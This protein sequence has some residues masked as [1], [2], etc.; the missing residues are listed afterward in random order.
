MPNTWF[1]VSF[2][3]DSSCLDSIA[4]CSRYEKAGTAEIPAAAQLRALFLTVKARGQGQISKFKGQRQPAG[5]E[6]LKILPSD[7]AV[8]PA[9]WQAV[10]HTIASP[11]IPLT[12]ILQISRHI[13]LRDRGSSSTTPQPAA[14]DVQQRIGMFAVSF[15]AAQNMANKP[16]GANIAYLADL[17]KPQSNLK[18]LLDRTKSMSSESLAPA[19]PPVPSPQLA[20]VS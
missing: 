11:R 16:Q 7:P 5:C 4:G 20:I 17:E 8:L 19:L 3:A 9:C 18:Q 1:E 10:S 15:L 13:Q 12:E 2:R 14:F 6:Y